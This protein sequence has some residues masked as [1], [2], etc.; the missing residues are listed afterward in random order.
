MGS[1]DGCASGGGGWL[2]AG[3]WLG[4]AAWLA[5]TVHRKVTEPVPPDEDVAVTVTW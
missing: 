5:V 4:A 3:G 1:D 2:D